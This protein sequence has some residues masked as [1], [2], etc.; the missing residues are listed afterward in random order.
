MLLILDALANALGWYFGILLLLPIAILAISFLFYGIRVVGFETSIIVER[1]GKFHRECG[2]GLHFLFPLIDRTRTF[3]WRDVQT[4]KGAQY[5]GYNGGN[6]ETFVVQQRISDVIDLRE[7]IMDF[8]SQPIITRDNVEITVHP[9]LLYKLIKPMR[10]VYETFDIS[11]AVEKIVQTTL[12]AIIGDMGMDDTLASREEINR[13][14]KT[15][16]QKIVKN[17]GM[18]I[19]RVEL[20]EITPT[21]TV[22]AA[23]NKQLIAERERRALIVSS[24]GYRLQTK[25]VA[26]GNCESVKALSTGEMQV[27]SLTAKGES[28][29]RIIV[30]EAEGKAISIIADALKDFDVDVSQY[31][32][33]LRYIETF[34][35]IAQNAAQRTVFLPYESDVVGAANTI[36]TT[37]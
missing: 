20:L 6:R 19:I 9:M 15:R 24:D 37:N 4:S 26:E 27:R 8:P 12:R 22:Q 23:M 13:A 28:E 2:P 18:L 36:G 14:L 31:I 30:A 5:G 1:F 16:I 32:V 34:K 21:S 25:M 3:R 17:W 7:N 33:G 35:V 10:V 29:A 11:H